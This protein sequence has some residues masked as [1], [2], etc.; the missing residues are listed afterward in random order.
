MYCR[1]LLSGMLPA[2]SLVVGLAVSFGMAEVLHPTG[3]IYRDLRKVPG[4][5]E[6][7]HVPVAPGAQPYKAFGYV[8]LL[9]EMPPIGDQGSQ[10]SCTAWGIAYYHKTQ[11]EGLIHHWDLTQPEHQFSPAF[12]YN[13][14]NGGEDDG[15][16][17][18]AAADLICEQGCSNL[19]D[20][21]YDEN[22]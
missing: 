3:L 15:S 21:P 4:M 20:D 1:R 14:I 16:D 7:K 18:G 10:G 13:Q 2:V 11:L 8:D 22:D 19:S 17:F 9:S 5:Q 12:L 6:V